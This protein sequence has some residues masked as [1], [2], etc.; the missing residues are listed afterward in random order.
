MYSNIALLEHVNLNASPTALPALRALYEGLLGMREDPRPSARGRSAEL[1]W[2]N[3][4]LS[5]VHLPLGEAGGGA[6]CQRVDGCLGVLLARGALRGGGAVAARLGSLAAP[7]PPHLLRRRG[8]ATPHLYLPASP[9]TLGTAFLLEESS[10]GDEECAQAMPDA[11]PHPCLQPAGA[12]AALGLTL[13][14]LRVPAAALPH[15]AAFFT[16]VLGARVEVEQGLAVTAFCDGLQLEAHGRQRLLFTA[17]EGEAAG[18]GAPPPLPYDGWHAAIYLRDFQG[19]FEAARAAGLLYDN[20]RFSDRCGT[21]AQAQEHHQFRTLALGQAQGC[22]LE[23][24]IRS[25]SHPHCPLPLRAPPAPP[26]RVLT[27]QSHVVW[28]HVGN[29]AATLP[30]QMLGWEVSPLNTVHFATHTGYPAVRG[31]RLAAGDVEAVLEGLRLNAVLGGFGALLTG[32]TPSAELLRVYG[33]LVAEVSALRAAAAAPPLIYVCD[34][35]LGDEEAGEAGGSSASAAAFGR[36]YVPKELIASFAAH[37]AA[38]RPTIL[39]PNAFEAA[40]LTGRSSSIR[41]VASAVQACAALHAM[42]ARCCVITSTWIALREDTFLL[43]ASA[44]WEDLAAECGAGGGGQGG[45]QRGSAG[46]WRSAAGGALPRPCQAH[47]QPWRLWHLRAS[48]ARSL[49]GYRGSHC[50]PAAGQF[51]RA[52]GQLCRGCGAQR[53]GS[54]Q[55]VQEDAG[56]CGSSPRARGRA[57]G[58]QAGRRRAAPGGLPA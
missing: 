9:A 49:H 58:C 14:Q 38:S 53:G 16:G 42:G 50:S 45:Q 31:Q 25:L 2:V 36:L 34:P 44:P 13:L 12:G 46:R 3:C 27:I 35:V 7:C 6:A 17:L 19:A 56:G 40:Q 32:Y 47:G 1:L 30:L 26:K 29:C 39:T 15:I 10:E 41:D 37:I 20:P 22:A 21:W 33:A 51:Q 18:G 5:Q 55:R 23:L 4:G 28:G 43:L 57:A 48:P 52:P 11:R 24:E 8:R 54:V